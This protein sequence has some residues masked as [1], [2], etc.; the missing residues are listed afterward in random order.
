MA[1]PLRPSRIQ[2]QLSGAEREGGREG[3]EEWELEE[4]DDAAVFFLGGT[5]K[6]GKGKEEEMHGRSR[7][8][9]N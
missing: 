9:G 3:V 4:A 6:G 7:R 2:P 5:P 1:K 8:E